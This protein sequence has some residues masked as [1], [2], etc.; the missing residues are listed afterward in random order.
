MTDE[1]RK[2]VKAVMRNTADRK[3]GTQEG[4]EGQ[5]GK[6]GNKCP[7]VLVINKINQGRKSRNYFADLDQYKR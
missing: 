7:H 4:Q 3:S 2:K 1:V 5:G 6:R